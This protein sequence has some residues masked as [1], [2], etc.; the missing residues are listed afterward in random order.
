MI[1][2]TIGKNFGFYGSNSFNLYFLLIYQI[3]PGICFDTKKWR[4]YT[5]ISTGVIMMI[6]IPRCL[7]NIEWVLRMLP[8]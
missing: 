1:F 6:F 7:E 8:R 4:F 3:D 2:S 5:Y